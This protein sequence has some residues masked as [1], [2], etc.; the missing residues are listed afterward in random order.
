MKRQILRALT[1][2]LFLESV[3]F[4]GLIYV[5]IKNYGPHS[6]FGLCMSLSQ[7]FGILAV[8]SIP[9]FYDLAQ[10][11]CFVNVIFHTGIF[12]VQV[13]VLA[14]LFLIFGKIISLFSKSHIK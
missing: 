14:I 5:E 6:V 10:K 12:L 1:L 7:F 11:S 2:A 9:S 4:L 3:F 8:N 13:V